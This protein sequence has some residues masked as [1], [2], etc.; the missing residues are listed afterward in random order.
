MPLSAQDL[1]AQVF[2]TLRGLRFGLDTAGYIVGTSGL[3]TEVECLRS[4]TRISGKG[5]TVVF[6]PGRYSL[7]LPIIGAEKQLVRR[8]TEAGLSSFNASGAAIL[9]TSDGTTYSAVN[10]A[11][12][13][14]VKLQAIAP[15]LWCVV[16]QL[17]SVSFS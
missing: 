13:S 5:T 1:R 12:T 15:A 7:P 9:A 17:G 14:T 2:S 8:S 3:R 6:A 11:G 4:G 10:L 16:S